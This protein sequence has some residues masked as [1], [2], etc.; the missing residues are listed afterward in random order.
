MLARF[1]FLTLFVKF[2]TLSP[3]ARKVAG[4]FFAGS[5]KAP[6]F[7]LHRGAPDDLIVGTC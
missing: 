4:L 7:V 6:S 5:S 3:V 1:A 2:G